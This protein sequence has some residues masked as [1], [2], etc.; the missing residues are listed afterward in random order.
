[1]YILKNALR[2]IGRAKGRNI[3]IGVIVLVIAVSSCLALSIRKAAETARE[4][5]LSGLEVTAQISL[6]RM[7]L[8]ENA[9]PGSGG[10]PDMSAML[11]ALQGADSL[12]LEEMETYAQAEC[13]KDFTYSP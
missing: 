1:M 3:L 10:K 5:T 9:E 2:S 11:G 13:V 8:M 4:E 6:D 12:T 7:Q